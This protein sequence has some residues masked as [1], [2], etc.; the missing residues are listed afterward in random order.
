MYTLPLPLP[1]ANMEPLS[2]TEVF[3]SSKM[4]E[5][6]FS[7]VHNPRNILT[8]VVFNNVVVAQALD[9]S[10][11]FDSV[12]KKHLD[13]PKIFASAVFRDDAFYTSH[14]LEKQLEPI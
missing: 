10:N 6:M 4:I 2:L 14:V 13:A 12:H 1:G 3:S 9:R 5:T 11:L 8:P 7:A